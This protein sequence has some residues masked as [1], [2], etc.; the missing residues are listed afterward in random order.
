MFVFGRKAINAATKAE[1]FN[2]IEKP[3][4]I[5]HQNQSFFPCDWRSLRQRAEALFTGLSN[6][7][8]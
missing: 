5:V 1:G 2:E 4:L 8:H 3:L 6:G 7:A